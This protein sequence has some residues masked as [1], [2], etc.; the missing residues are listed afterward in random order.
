MKLVAH[1]ISTNSSLLG[2]VSRNSQRMDD[3]STW[4]NINMAVYSMSL[5]LSAANYERHYC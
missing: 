4:S 5:A 1:R 3:E 2:S